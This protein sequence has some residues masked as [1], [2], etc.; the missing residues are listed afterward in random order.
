MPVLQLR[1]VFVSPYEAI[2][3]KGVAYMTK[4]PLIPL[5]LVLLVMVSIE[6]Q[7]RRVKG[8]EEPPLPQG[9]ATLFV[10]PATTHRSLSELTSATDLVIDGVVERADSRLRNSGPR[11]IE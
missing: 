4:N 1:I 6:A 7:Q 2:V 3:K 5:M 10:S 8:Q 11:A 9:T